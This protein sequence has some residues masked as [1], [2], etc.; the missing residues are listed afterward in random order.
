MPLAKS[1]QGLNHVA[2]LFLANFEYRL[3]TSTGSMSCT[4]ATSVRARLLPLDAPARLRSHAASPGR[5][6]LPPVSAP[7]SH[8]PPQTPPGCGSLRPLQLWPPSTRSPE[9]FSGSERDPS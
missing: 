8:P 4:P 6:C 9:P 5:A 2:G 7:T 3:R 1:A